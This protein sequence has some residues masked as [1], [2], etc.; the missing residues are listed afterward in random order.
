[1]VFSFLFNRSLMR[2][3]NFFLILILNTLLFQS[4]NK[5]IE[6]ANDQLPTGIQISV[7]ASRV[8]D[9]IDVSTIVKEIA[10]TPLKP[11]EGD[12]LSEV[13]KVIYHDNLFIVFDKYGSQRIHIYNANGELYKSIVPTGNGP[14]EVSHITDC[15]ID[16]NGH[17]EI[18][19]SSLNRILLF[20]ENYIPKR[21]FKGVDRLS[22]TAI[23][24]IENKYI[25]FGGFNTTHNN[26]YFK[27][28]ILDDSFKIVN[29]AFYYDEIFRG[30]LI[31]TPTTPFGKVGDQYIFSQNYDKTIYNISKSGE[32]SA[33]YQINYTPNPFPDDFNEKVVRENI[34]LF[35]SEPVDFESQNRLYDGYSGFSG[36]WLE[37]NT[38]SIFNSFDEKNERFVSIYNKDSNKII[39]QGKSLY[40]TDRKLI[41]PYIPYLSTVNPSENCFYTVIERFLLIKFIDEDSPNYG[42]VNN[43]ENESYFLV[44]ICL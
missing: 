3:D 12:Y 28:G 7:D 6:N 4:C 30:A 24:K 31:T 13:W 23:Q 27:V 35:K 10:I 29:A 42:L 26:E 1:M 11:N 40:L 41:I 5:K 14:N 22:L 33:R 9:S 21:S 37:T 18:Y 19:D 34:R 17:L 8:V 36:K 38:Y 20:D 25:T 16:E 43:E 32:F 44:K 15:W 2:L 39:A